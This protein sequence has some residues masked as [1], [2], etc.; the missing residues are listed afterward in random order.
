[1]GELPELLKKLSYLKSA[2]L[3]FV[4]NKISVKGLRDI[5]SCI[6]SLGE[7]ELMVA[8]NLIERSEIEDELKGYKNIKLLIL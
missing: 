6:G 5:L 8:D 4:S 2:R 1:V 3:N 7:V